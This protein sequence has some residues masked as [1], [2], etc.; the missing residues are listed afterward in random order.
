M[1]KSLLFCFA[2]LFAGVLSVNAQREEWNAGPFKH[3]SLGIGAGTA[4]I[5]VELA[6]TLGS[7]FQLRAGVS[8]L[9]FTYSG[10]FEIDNSILFD[11]VNQSAL[12]AAGI[13]PT[14]LPDEV[15]MD[16]ELG[17]MN[18]KV[19]LDIY[20]FKK[21]TF[22]ITAGAYF[23]KDKLINVEGHMPKE[24]MDAANAVR[25]Y[26][27]GINLGDNFI[28]AAQDGSVDAF[29]KIN[30]VK[31]YVGIGFGRA[32]PKHRLGLDFDLG[33]MFHGTP[34]ID[35]SNSAVSGKLNDELESSGLTDI[36]EEITIYPVMSLRLVGRIF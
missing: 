1:K 10:E 3:L 34:K 26:V 6:T 18:G 23:G 29:V 35:S 32:V 9:P 20:P 28:E 2:L 19:L 22:R 33:V 31:P 4:G 13:D 16:A 5:D 7:H 21:A 17:L 15:E 14:K 36:L 12:N 11:G 30:K 8:A 25:E 27:P 24:V